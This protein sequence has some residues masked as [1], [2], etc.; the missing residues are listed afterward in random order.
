MANY[1]TA[2]NETYD[3][4]NSAAEAMK[5]KINKAGGALKDNVDKVQS[6]AAAA[7]KTIRDHVTERPI[8]SLM[9]GLAAGV[10]VGLILGRR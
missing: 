5:D 10:V 4:G 7:A 3:T 6:E 8:T 2:R 1:T 9:V